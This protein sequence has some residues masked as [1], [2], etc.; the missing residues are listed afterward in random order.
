MKN[1]R[2]FFVVSDQ[3]DGMLGPSNFLSPRPGLGSRAA[4]GCRLALWPSL[5]GGRTAF[6]LRFFMA[7]SP[8]AALFLQYPP[9]SPE[10]DGSAAS[11]IHFSGPSETYSGNSSAKVC[12]TSWYSS[13]GISKGAPPS[14]S[15]K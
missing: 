8:L 10:Y 7:D 15:K 5:P 1:I 6:S 12:T 13:S 3:V 4:S 2:L 14:I 11:Q 9:Q